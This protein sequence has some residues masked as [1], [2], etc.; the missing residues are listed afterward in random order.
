MTMEQRIRVLEE[1]VAHLQREKHAMLDA[2]E[3]AADLSNFQT[4]LNKIED[5]ILIIRDTAERLRRILDFKT[6]S[7]YLVNEDDS[8][9]VQVYTDPSHFVSKI[10]TE[11]SA[12]IE[13]KTFAW[14][15]GRYKPV[16]VTSID[17]QD[18]IILHALATSSRVRGI[19][20]GILNTSRHDITDLS[21]FLFSITMNA[22]SNALESFELYRR[23]RDRSRQLTENL[24]LIEE[25]E[26]KYRALFEQSTNSILLLDAETMLPVEFNDVACVNLG[27]SREEF[28]TLRIEDC[29]IEVP[30]EDIHTHIGSSIRKGLV[31][32]ETMYRCKDGQIRYMIVNSRVLCIQE[33]VY[34]LKVLTDITRQKEQE[35]QRIHLEKQLRQSQKMESIGT[36]AGGIAHDFNNILAIILGYAELSLLDLPAENSSIRKNFTQLIKAV[37]RAKKLVMQI[38]TFSRQGEEVCTPLEINGIVRESLTLLRATLPSTIQFQF[39]IPDQPIYILGDPTQIHQVLMNICTNSFQA[40][41]NGNGLLKVELGEIRLTALNQHIPGYTGVKQIQPGN[42]AQITVTDTGHGMDTDVLE[43]VFDPYFTTK[44]AGEGTGLGLAVVHGIVEK[45]NGH[46]FIES[47]PDKGTQVKVRIPEIGDWMS[48]QDDSEP[49]FL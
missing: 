7:F 10:A 28:K 49:I 29:E 33:K 46:I 44:K 14:A 8:D 34:I 40:M 18:N 15:L 45:Y 37:E 21:L 17:K 27:Y 48:Q 35:A 2:I 22:C 24:H 16:I 1:Q 12:L 25:K 19:M 13:D 32:F 42:Y 36:L 3:C 23:I 41:K 30:Q 20:V 5:P 31:T 11:V 39:V 9:F 38:L 47:T 26:E 43:R 4:S 6:V